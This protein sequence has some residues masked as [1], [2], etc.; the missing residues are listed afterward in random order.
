MAI[1]RY[2]AV[3]PAGRRLRGGLE[4]ASDVDL[5]LRLKR[6]G[7]DLIACRAAR[8]GVAAAPARALRRVSGSTRRVSRAELINF[9]FDLEQTGRCGIPLLD[10]LRDLRD[11]ASSPAF[12]PVLENLVERIAAGEMLSTSL[13]A[14][15]QVFAEVFV[16]LVRAG[17]ETGRLPEVFGSLAA[18]LRWQDELAART[19]Q[20]LIYPALVLAVLL[21][22]IAFLL[23]VLVPQVATLLR[24]LALELP[25]QT[26]VLL[27]L[28]HATREYWMVALGAPVAGAAALTYAVR[29][30][31]RAAYVKDALLLQLPVL[32]PVLKKLVLARF[33]HF[34]ALMY[35]AGIPII[36]ALKTSEAVAGQRVVRAALAQAGSRV[37]AGSSLADAFRVSGIFP[38]LVLRMLGMG[39]KTGALDVALRQVGYFYTREVREA[40]ERA[41]RLLEPVLT[42]LLGAVLAL[43]LWCV[44]TPLYDVLGGLKL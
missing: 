15:P 13:A 20:L 8:S 26:R 18:S 21:G 9:C 33:A 36:E 27:A 39:E 24:T 7:L 43:L 41:L 42:L 4:A 32:G 14:H 2:L 5:E 10:A 11:E 34:L 35:E 6:L 23:V 37:E 22:V 1:F 3:D 25:P 16:G 30:S 38:P 29:R 28:A 12:A 19:G 44:L 40:T 17:E 31:P